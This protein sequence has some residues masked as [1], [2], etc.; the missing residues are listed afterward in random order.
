M[1]RRVPKAIIMILPLLFILVLAMLLPAIAGSAEAEHNIT[2]LEH[3]EG[4][5]GGG[6]R[7]LPLGRRRALEPADGGGP[8]LC[9]PASGDLLPVPQEHGGRGSHCQRNGPVT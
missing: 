7:P 8:A 6:A 2:A 4:A 5:A 9:H 1:S 3:S